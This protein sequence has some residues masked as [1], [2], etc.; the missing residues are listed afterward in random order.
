MTVIFD[1]KKFALEKE[2]ELK[3]RV[4]ALHVT[5][6]LVSIL[7]G[8]NEASSLYTKL[9]QNAAKRI[10]IDFVIKKLPETAT[11]EEIISLITELSNDQ[12]V[13]GIM[14]QLPLPPKL[15]KWKA[16]IMKAID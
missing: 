14:V 11:K 6:V 7:V 3:I 1:G 4:A 16:K 13:N 10:G 2:K 8:T 15:E 9:K 12:K 5:P